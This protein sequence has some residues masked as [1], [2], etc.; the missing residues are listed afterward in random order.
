MQREKKEKNSLIQQSISLLVETKKK[1]GF[2]LLTQKDEHLCSSLTCCPENEPQLITQGFLSGPPL[3]DFVFLCNKGNVHVCTKQEC[4]IFN[5]TSNG[6]CPISRIHY[7]NHSFSSYSRADSRTWS[8]KPSSRFCNPGAGVF[9][10][11]IRKR[12]KKKR[13]LLTQSGINIVVGKKQEPEPKQKLPEPKPRR[14]KRYASTISLIPNRSREIVQILLYSKHRKDINNI[15]RT[16][17][18]SQLNKRCEEYIKQC[19]NER[20]RIVLSDLARFNTY[21]S[22]MALPLSE[23]KRNESII[24]NYATIIQHVW[25]IVY[26]FNNNAIQNNDEYCGPKLCFDSIALGA[27]Y[28]MRQGYKINSIEVLPQDR[29]LLYNLPIIN[30]LTRFGFAKKK[31]TKGENLLSIAYK[32]AIDSGKISREDLVVDVTK[33]KTTNRNK[34]RVKKVVAGRSSTIFL[35]DN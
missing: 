5:S 9:S 32:N 4:K 12:K 29:F 21:Y 15:T 2:L 22:N 13:K 34:K 23:M 35:R 17:H 3:T 19:A 14:R 16:K 7:A 31:I 8:S 28:T 1:H 27:L 30:D 6:I 18:Q 11:V 25:N 10:N 33:M 24:D 20:Q 26:T